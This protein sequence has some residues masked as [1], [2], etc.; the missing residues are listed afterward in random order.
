[1]SD[2][3]VRAPSASV[4]LLRNPFAPADR[5]VFSAPDNLSI[6]QWLNAQAP[7]VGAAVQLQPTICLKNGHPVLRSDWAVTKVEGAIIF[8]ALPQGGGGGGGKNPLRTVLMIAVMVVA[9]VY[10][11]PLASALGFS[12]S[13]GTAVASAGIALAGSV[14]VNALVP[15]PTP[16][17]P[18]AASFS[19]PSPTYSLQAQGN[20]ARLTQPIP[21]VYGHHL[22]FPDFASTPY[23][24]Y[25]D[26]DQYLHQLHVIG[27]G[28]Y[29]IH[30]IRIEDTPIQSFAEIQAQ[31]ILPGGVNTLFNH[32]VVTAP[33]VAGQELIALADPGGA[34]VGPFTVSPPQTQVS[35]IGIDVLMLRGLYYANDDGSLSAKSVQWRVEVRLLDD[36]GEATSGWWVLAEA[37]HSAATGESQRLSLKYAVSPGRYQVRMTRLDSKDPSSRAGHELRWGEV[38]GYLAGSSLPQQMTLLAL[39]MKA[40]DNLSQRS[41]RMVN[42]LVTRKLPTWSPQ[43]GWSSPVATRSIA[44]AFADALRADYGAGLADARIDLQAL[45]R[46]DQQWTVRGDCFDAVFD[47]GLTVWEALGRVARCGR[48]VP[49]MQGGI[50][51]VV[52]DEPKALPVALFSMRNIVRGSL[53]IQYIMP[54]EETADTVVMGYVNPKTW[55]PDEVTVALPGSEQDRQAKVTLFGCTSQ[56]QVVREGKYIAAANRYRRRLITFTTEMEGLIPTYGDLIAIS[57]DMPSWGTSG[58]IVGFD[59]ASRAMTSSV[60]LPWEEGA[61]HH[62]A[63]QQPDGSVAGPFL[64]MRGVADHLAVV[65][66]TAPIDLI[67]A[68]AAGPPHFSFGIG[69]TWSQLARVMAI[70]PRGEQV[71]I[72][73]VVEHPLVHTADQ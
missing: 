60:P 47:Q 13:L 70:R 52:R 35:H 48:A 62:L 43:V 57:H 34:V 32:D 30:Q 25:V 68:I 61:E 19:G 23:A 69:Q 41:S 38:R 6:S 31:V 16:N 5:E 33:E 64:V 56:A 2:V 39:R 36:A 27:M 24:E 8:V 21:V 1:M 4:I 51:R 65:P 46:L 26:H 11:G 28:E 37:S 58:E 3:S 40:T 49:F 63:F 17:V 14:L 12:G 22:V 15:L 72:A 53:K 29:E 44:W 73:C 67:D 7:Q 45:Y 71:E 42:C 59:T 55:K 54:G 18:T 10:G 66:S 9:N 50:V 20:Y